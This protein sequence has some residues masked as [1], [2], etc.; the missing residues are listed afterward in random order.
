M[1][2]HTSWSGRRLAVIW[3]AWL[4]FAA[5][6]LVASLGMVLWRVHR[7]ESTA[8][9]RLSGRHSDVV[10]SY[11]GSEL[12]WAVVAVL[13]PPVLLTAVWLWQRSGGRGAPT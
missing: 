9:T 8:A 12:R 4:L 1:S 5:I 11:A 7:L 2:G 3:T 13:V 6:A 10:I